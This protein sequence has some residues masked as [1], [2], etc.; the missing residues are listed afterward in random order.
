M[1]RSEDAKAAHPCGVPKYNI[2]AWLFS[3]CTDFEL[4]LSSVERD[5]VVGKIHAIVNKVH[6]YTASHVLTVSA[7]AALIA[8]GKLPE[9]M[10]VMYQRIEDIYF[11]ERN[12]KTT[13]FPWQSNE[14]GEAEIEWVAENPNPE[15][16]R[17]VE[18]DGK[19]IMQERTPY[20]AAFGAY[21]AA[22]DD[23]NRALCI[24]AHH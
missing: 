23:G 18:K 3:Y 5:R 10:P 15:N 2:L 12:W 6:D 14:A 21:V 4:P 22:D 17:I 1:Y 7:L 24:H 9:N 16:Y 11:A 20:I 8:N 13:S 19:K